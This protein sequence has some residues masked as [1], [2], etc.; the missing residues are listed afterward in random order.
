MNSFKL[1]SII[2]PT[3][4]EAENLRELTTSISDA[5]GRS[6]I[7][8]EQIIVDDDSGDG[9]ETIVK[10]LQVKGYPVRMITR[11][12][13][14]GLSTA[15]IRGFQEALGD[16][17]VCMDADLS[18][19]PEALL[20]LLKVIRNPGADFALGSRYVKG[21][22]TDE[23]WGLFDGSTVNWPRSWPGHLR[24]SKTPC[25]VFLCCPNTCSTNTSS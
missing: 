14:R 23:N 11:Q 13:E 18:H 4:K 7:P 2:V 1:L 16:V 6:D 17:L 19:P 3:F 21:A 12:G 10:E 25:P 8:Y 9:S 24:G 5:L 20:Q 15:V 22:S